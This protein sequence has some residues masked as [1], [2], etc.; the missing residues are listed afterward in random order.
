MATRDFN[1]WRRHSITLMGEA[2]QAGGGLS[3]VDVDTT[4]R[5]AA[6]ERGLRISGATISQKAR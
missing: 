1:T 3:A 4:S 6:L 2:D 5:A